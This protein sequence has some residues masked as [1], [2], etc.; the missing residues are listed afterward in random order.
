MVDEQRLEL[1]LEAREH[2]GFRLVTRDGAVILERPTYEALRR[3]LRVAAGRSAQ[4]G[5]VVVLVGGPA[6]GRPVT[7]ADAPA[8]E[9]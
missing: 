5:P 3:D 7:R 4:S 1:F 8:L 2:G 9:T 6:R